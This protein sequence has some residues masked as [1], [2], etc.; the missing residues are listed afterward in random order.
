MDA[1]VAEG[2]GTPG[3]LV[4]DRVGKKLGNNVPGAWNK[5]SVVDPGINVLDRWPITILPSLC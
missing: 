5:T 3:R 1:R 4:P 2:P